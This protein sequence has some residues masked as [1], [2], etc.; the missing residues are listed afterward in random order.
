MLKRWVATVVLGLMISGVACG[1]AEQRPQDDA[2][3]DPAATASEPSGDRGADCQAYV[4]DSTVTYGPGTALV[5]QYQAPEGWHVIESLDGDAARQH[6]HGMDS[7]D[8]EDADE[9]QF[10]VVQ[11]FNLDDIE[12]PQPFE[13]VGIYERY[14][15]IE[16]GGGSLDLWQMPAIADD[17]GTRQ[18]QASIPYDSED[19]GT[20]YPNV[21]IQTQVQSSDAEACAEEIVAV[22]DA[23]LES[24]EPNPDTTF[25]AKLDAQ[26]ASGQ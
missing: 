14:K 17:A 24:M 3:D 19:H 5:F 21:M 15:T 6:A 11:N 16:Y 8:P 20:L 4:P 13:D 25:E 12:E 23:M 18:V 7:D 10:Q 2:E 9:V 26:A 22:F 1:G